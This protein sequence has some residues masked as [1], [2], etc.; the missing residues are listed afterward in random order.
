MAEYYP[1]LSRAISNLGTTNAD[2][3][4]AIYDRA[5]L[6]LNKQLGNIQPPLEPSALARESAA[7]ETAISQLE[8]E[9]LAIAAAPSTDATPAPD[10]TAE[11]V[12][13]TPQSAPVE[14]LKSE[15]SSE[16]KAELPSESNVSS[17]VAAVPNAGP[18]GGLKPPVSAYQP[19]S[20]RANSEGTKTDRAFERP[21]Q[22]A[23]PPRGFHLPGIGL[24]ATG[25]A[26]NNAADNA[27]KAS[28]GQASTGQASRATAATA[29]E[30]GM[31]HDVP[32]LI[33]RLKSFGRPLIAPV[34]AAVAED[35][36][37]TKPAPAG[38]EFEPTDGFDDEREM[39]RPVV[40][41][42][43]DFSAGRMRGLVFAG[44]IG[45]VVLA[46]AG[47]AYRLRD[48]PEDLAKLRAA[49]A[50]RT[51]Q[52]ASGK[53][54]DR[55]GGPPR[56]ATPNAPSRSGTQTGDK[57]TETAPQDATAGIAALPHAILLLEMPTEEGGSK[58]YEGNVI[59]RVENVSRG[60]GQQVA[61]A[62]RADIDLAELKLKISMSI[63]KNTDSTLPASHI[64]E[65]RFVPAPDSP[66]VGIAQTD[67]LAM[68]RD[69]SAQPEFLQ[70][71]PTPIMAN[72]FL[73][74]LTLSE[75]A[76]A[77]NLD[78]LRT[79]GQFDVMLRMKNDLRARFAFEKGPSGDKIMS[80][81]IDSWSR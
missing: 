8:A 16:T 38:D 3:R 5:R 44:I 9:Q 30:S 69:D 80:E 77:S 18:L 60:P 42:P 55:V 32:S 79:R 71:V 65:L 68:R 63:F 27:D 11:P 67:M 29:A 17:V 43:E 74:G 37:E 41:P 35:V 64:I 1:L 23:A 70:G 75:R 39:Q 52:P 24:P 54:V 72:F 20:D 45:V 26:K 78:L 13:D 46:V 81:A 15:I 21:L 58:R 76:T 22:P 19:P 12:I 56:P 28:T 14:P 66:F 4:R 7:L 50:E 33:E 25:L 51:D 6:A 36:V 62:V 10:A 2:T 73:F 31:P 49:N 47:A 61:S 34:P 57:T 40:M 48:R 53:I 59:W